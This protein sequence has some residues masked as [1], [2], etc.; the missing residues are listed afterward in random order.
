MSLGQD[1][2]QQD[3]KIQQRNR[4]NQK[5]F[6]GGASMEKPTGRRRSLSDPF[7]IPNWEIRPHRWFA[8]ELLICLRDVSLFISETCS[9]RW[10]R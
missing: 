3:A 7:R 5:T 9:E 10:P 8:E 6:C 1:P 2:S 4:K